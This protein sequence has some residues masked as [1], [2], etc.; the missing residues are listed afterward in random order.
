MTESK[1]SKNIIRPGLDNDF[2]QWQLPDV[3]QPQVSDPANLFGHTARVSHVQAE[4]EHIQPPTMAE[5][6]QMRA[7]AEA[8]GFEEGKQQG[9]QS[10]LE[11]GRLQGLEQGHNEG[12]AQGLQQ[13]I[14][15][16]LSQARTLVGRFEALLEQFQRPLSLLDNEIELALINLSMGLAKAVVGNELKTHPEHILAALRQG[17]DALPI[18]EQAVTIRVNPIDAVLIQQ[19]YSQAQLERHQWQLDEDPILNLGDCI[20]TSQRSAVDLRLSTRLDSV[21]AELNEQQAYLAQQIQ[22]QK[23]SLEQTVAETSKDDD[24]AKIDSESVGELDAQSPTPTAE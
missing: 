16:G 13:G 8:E 10:G 21:F 5:I 2:S 20:L 19:F 6:E 18:K 17:V 3:T 14:E 22:Q 11:E 24:A 7:E 4:I 9:L 12:F 1:P 23:Q 15:E